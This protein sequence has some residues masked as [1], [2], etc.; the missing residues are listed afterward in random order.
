MNVTVRKAAVAVLVSLTSAAAFAHGM[1][2]DGRALADLNLNSAQKAQ[3]EKIEQQYRPA[4]QPDDTAR[5]AQYQQWQQK[6][7]QLLKE[8]VFNENSARQLIQ[9]RQQQQTERELQ[10]LRKQHAVFQVLNAEQQQKWL[11]KRDQTQSMAHK[12]KGGH[13]HHHPARPAPNAASAPAQ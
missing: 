6:K 8:R 11:A 10:H 5:Q 2:G 13:P 4:S 9:Q 12:H 3:I 1:R 7:Q